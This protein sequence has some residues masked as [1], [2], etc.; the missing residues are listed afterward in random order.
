MT[1]TGTDGTL[2]LAV[3]YLLVGGVAFLLHSKPATQK[4]IGLF[5]TTATLLEGFLLRRVDPTGSARLTLALAAG[6]SI[7]ADEPGEGSEMIPL[8]LTLS[9]LGFGFLGGN[10]EGLSLLFYAGILALLILIFRRY[11]REAS[12]P[13]AGIGLAF[14]GIFLLATSVASPPPF[15]E[16]ALC[17]AFA[18][19]LPLFPLHGIYQAALTDTP[20]SL[21]VFLAVLLPIV[22]L[23][24]ILALRVDIPPTIL[25]M[26]SAL[27]VAG[28]VYGSLKASLDSRM[29]PL[30]AYAGLAF[31]STLW[32]YLSKL[33]KSGL[34]PEH[35]PSYAAS[36]AVATSGLLLASRQ[37]QLR[38]GSFDIEKLGGLAREMPRFGTLL[39]LLATAGM[40]LP[41]FG[42]FTGFMKMTAQT[43]GFSSWEIGFIL[44]AWFFASCHFTL[45]IQ[46]LL[47]GPPRLG[48]IYKDLQG[49]EIFPLVVAL[50]WLLLSGIFPSFLF[51]PGG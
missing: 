39:V 36:I 14:A 44:L 37:L 48:L 26:I 13:G 4:K 11:R 49:S 21:P 3:I 34:S 46:R 6:L 31:F 41:L 24:G 28:V 43:V 2:F 12:P 15:P 29:A 8:I 35:A 1:E 40:G 17:A 42:P 50:F 47:L 18:L 30:F 16:I 19:F 25:Q 23:H 51:G 20:G 9:G 5:L 7:F 33:A 32:W 38:Y 22:G 45:L 27:A 10:G